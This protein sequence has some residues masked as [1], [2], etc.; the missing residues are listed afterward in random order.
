MNNLIR[1]SITFWLC[2]IHSC[3][4]WYPNDWP[5]YDPVFLIIHIAHHLAAFIALLMQHLFYLFLLLHRNF[6]KFA[7]Q[8]N[9]FKPCFVD[10]RSVIHITVPLGSWKSFGSVQHIQH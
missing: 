1:L 6:L 2:N 8:K 4:Y 9:L 3:K 5:Q 7:T 10:C